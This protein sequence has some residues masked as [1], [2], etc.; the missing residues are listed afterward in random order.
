MIAQ[1]QGPSYDAQLYWEILPTRLCHFDCTYCFKN[2]AGQR[3]D[4]SAQSP[5]KDS[6]FQRPN[7][8]NK[9]LRASQMEF[10]ALLHRLKLTL[11]KN[12]INKIDIPAFVKMLDRTRKIFK[13][14]STGGEPFLV[15]NLVEACEKITQRHYI[16]FNTNLVTGE[17]RK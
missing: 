8:L 1:N 4:P 7:L 15:P 13:I 2:P 6:G 17:I 14:T 9:M 16:S 11:R 5:S 10:P 3:L 12:K